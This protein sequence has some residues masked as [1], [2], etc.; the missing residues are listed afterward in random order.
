M[1]KKILIFGHYGIPNWGDEAI[2]KGM[3]SQIDISKYSITIVSHNPSFTQ[4]EHGVKSVS[5]PPFG[6]KSFFKFS[7]IETIQEIKK[8]DYIIFGG[9]G[10]WQA[11]PKKALYLWD[12]YLRCVLFFSSTTK[13]FCLGTSFATLPQKFPTDEMKKRL[14]KIKYFS[15]R[16]NSSAKT[17]KEQWGIM[18]SK[19]QISSDAAFFLD[20]FLQ[21]DKN[22]TDEKKK[23]II[24]SMREGDLNREEEKIIMKIL[25][26][27]FKNHQ[28]Q[29]LV[30]QS[31][32]ANDEKFAERYCLEKI[33]P[34]SI[35]EILAFISNADCVISS[36]LHA[37]ILAS[38]CSIPF[39]A[40]SCR[41]KTKNLFG[42][43]FSVQKKNI[44][45]KNFKKIFLEKI[46]KIMAD[47]KGRKEFLELQKDKLKIFFP[48]IL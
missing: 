9:G 35:D 43:K 38:V 2:L 39:C 12:W 16:D 8:S 24:I 29:F 48:K 32:Q 44:G 36:R 41:Q 3:L 47:E 27:K 6:I 13:I 5:P 4:K 10:L 11:R 15:V 42:E 33:F 46:E 31:F 40:I 34:N 1:R 21:K 26:K 17:L 37:N 45:N 30:M 25:Q 7:W 28:F 23:K 22:L 20:N 14:Q 18:P 19:I